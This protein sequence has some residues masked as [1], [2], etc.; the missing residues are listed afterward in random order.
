MADYTTFTEVDPSS[1]ITV[2]SATRIDY[3]GLSRNESAYVYLDKGAAYYSG[4]FTFDVDIVCTSDT[5]GAGQTAFCYPWGVCNSVENAKAVITNSGQLLTVEMQ[6]STAPVLVV[7]EYY[8][9]TRYAT[10][11]TT[12]LSYATTYYLR[13]RRDEAVGTYGT[14]YLDLYSDAARTSL[15]E[16]KT[17][18]LHALVDFRY[19][20]AAN[21]YNDG[22]AW[23]QTGYTSNLIDY[24]SITNIA[25]PKVNFNFTGK[26]PGVYNSGNNKTIAVGKVN[27]NF[28]GKVPT[29]TTSAPTVIPVPVATFNFSRYAPTIRTND[30]GIQV[31]KVNFNF[32]GK[33]PT[34]SMT[35]HAVIAVPKATFNFTGKVPS[36]QLTNTEEEITWGLFNKDGDAI[37]GASPTIKIRSRATGYILD[38][39][40]DTF[41]AGGGSFPTS[42]MQEMDATNFQGYY[43]KIFTMTGW[44]DGWYVAATSY[45]PATYPADPKQ[46]GSIEFKVQDGLVVDD[47]NATNLDMAVSA[48]NTN[49]LTRLP[50][51][52]YTAPDNAGIAS[53]STIV[54]LLRKH[55][56]NKM[57]EVDN[58]NRTKTFTVYDNDNT[59]AI[60]AYTYNVDT[61]TRVKAVE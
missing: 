7:A 23:A 30:K 32:T 31:G 21:T 6:S 51:A 13:I 36:V 37:T 56:T 9:G 17:V 46:N 10:A 24:V 55:A 28:T 12:G 18:T 2:T 16:T 3:S 5:G 53:I 47:Y 1:H 40:D 33:V 61:L 29:I 35:G 44:S 8:N 60:L 50:T 59:T 27:F 19:L 39:S 57:V 15:T 26:V 49:V 20:Y 22:A 4:D 43:R 52:S 34:V 14:L 41:K 48:V 25:V 38:W 42:V 58:G 11:L 54:T 45:T